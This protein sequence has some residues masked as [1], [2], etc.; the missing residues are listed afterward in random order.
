MNRKTG[1]NKLTVDLAVKSYQVFLAAAVVS[2][3]AIG[4][5]NPMV[6]ALGLFLAFVSLITAYY[7]TAKINE[8]EK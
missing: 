6:F 4:H 5:F 8:E 3:W 2:P 7:Y 1:I